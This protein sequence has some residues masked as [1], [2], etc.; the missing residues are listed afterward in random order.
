MI[1]EQDYTKTEKDGVITFTP[2]KK[3]GERSRRKQGEKFYYVSINWC[4]DDLYECRDRYWEKNFLYWN[5][6]HT[7][8]QAQAVADLRRHVYK[9][10]AQRL[11][12]SLAVSKEFK[13]MLI[14]D[15]YTMWEFSSEKEKDERR[16]LVRRCLELN[17]YVTI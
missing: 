9:F 11:D 5:Y 8:E 1:N 2:K 14:Y 16:R 3:E 6:Y 12:D 10:P 7:E 15:P 4:V 17:G 13:W